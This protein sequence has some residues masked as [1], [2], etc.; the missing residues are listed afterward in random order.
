VLGLVT[1]GIFTTDPVDGFP[2]GAMA[3]SGISW[4]GFIH[5]L[6]GL[7]I[8]LVLPATL[9]IYARFF[10]AR[11]ERAWAF[12]CLASAVLA[13]GLFFSGINNAVLGARIL[14]LATFIGWLA[15]SVIAIRLLAGPETTASR[16]AR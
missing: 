10:L 3:P 2:P 9:L 16:I 14:R 8:F 15:A 1:V 4:H 6:G 5:G 7:F 13:F 12:Y 11:K